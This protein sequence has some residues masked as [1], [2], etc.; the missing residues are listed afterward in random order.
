MRTLILALLLLLP[1]ATQNTLLTGLAD[2][3]PML[4]AMD[5]NPQVAKNYGTDLDDEQRRANSFPI[6]LVRPFLTI[7]CLAYSLPGKYQTHNDHLLPVPSD[8]LNVVLR[9]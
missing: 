1:M 4:T 2:A 9:I 6:S 7:H 8:Q 3:I 5:R